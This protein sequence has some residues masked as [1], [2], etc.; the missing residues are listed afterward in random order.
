MEIRK[1]SIHNYTDE[2]SNK[3]PIL[4]REMQKRGKLFTYNKISYCNVL[5]AD[6]G[7]VKVANSRTAKQKKNYDYQKKGSD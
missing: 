7:V 3:I 2:K 1:E 4:R 5:L 6:H